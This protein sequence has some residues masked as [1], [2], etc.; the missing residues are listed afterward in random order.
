MSLF[1]TSLARYK[2]YYTLLWHHKK[3]FIGAT[4]CGVVYAAAS[5]FGLPYLLQELLPVIFHGEKRDVATILLA[6]LWLPMIMAV[7][8][9]AGFANVYLT[10]FCGLKVL[11]EVR[12]KVF[13]HLQSLPLSFFNNQRSGDLL[14]RLTLDCQA[15]QVMIVNVSNDLIRQPLQFIGA[16]VVLVYFA[17]TNDQ[18][19]VILMGMCVA[20]LLFFPI[21]II[22]K[23]LLQKA[24]QLQRQAGQISASLTDSLQA[25]KEIRAY[26]LE[27]REVKRFRVETEDLF[28][29][30][31]KLVKYINCLTPINEFL[32]ACAVG[33]AIAYQGIVGMKFDAM[34]PLL[35]ALHMAYEPIKKISAAL[36]LFQKSKASLERLEDILHIEDPMKDSESA[37]ELKPLSSIEFD[38]VSFKYNNDEDYVLKN[39]NVKFQKN[40]IIALVGGSGAGKSTFIQLLPRFYDVTSGE[41]KWNGDN[42]KDFKKKDLRNHFS[43]V[44]QD[45]VLFNDTIENNITLGEG[46]VHRSACES[47]AKLA[48]AHEF[49]LDQPEG[50]LTVNG[51]RGTLLSGGQKQRIAIARAFYKDAPVL[52]LDEATSALDSESEHSIQKSLAILTK[53]KTAFIVAHR[54]STIKIA[55]RI[56]VF[57]KGEIIADG[58]HEDLYE[59]CALYKSLCDHQLK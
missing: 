43:L 27:E 54:F 16:V 39:I 48:N 36:G 9:V 17:L 41:I 22:G 6:A 11:E 15:V 29:K 23:R 4:L 53:G 24:V 58:K 30:N 19:G 42:I 18:V 20:P 2:P 57:D 44:S 31:M 13:T 37:I 56:L 35:A 7:R 28:F 25:P 12:I 38:N 3:V 33:G 10:N 8:G 49:I 14:S 51:E 47:A 55:T 5:G 21:R 52:V 46:S 59:S 26:N 34:V 45:P 50:Y 32:A 1:P 40:E